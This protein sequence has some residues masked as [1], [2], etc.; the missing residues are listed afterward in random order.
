MHNH[1]IPS[2]LLAILFACNSACHS[3]RKTEAVQPAF[4]P[5]DTVYIEKPNGEVE[6]KVIQKVGK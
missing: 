2:L 5:G 1:L 6:M 4:Q 3:P